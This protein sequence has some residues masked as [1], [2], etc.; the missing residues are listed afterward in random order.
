M[1]VWEEERRWKREVKRHKKLREA[2]A[3][4]KRNETAVDESE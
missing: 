2:E 1:V 4:A 3:I